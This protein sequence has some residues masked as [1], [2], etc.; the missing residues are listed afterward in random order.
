MYQ[1]HSDLAMVLSTLYG[2]GRARLVGNNYGNFV[3]FQVLFKFLPFFVLF[4]KTVVRTHTT[5]HNKDPGQVSPYS[6]NAFFRNKAANSG[7]SRAAQPNCSKNRF[8]EKTNQY[9]TCCFGIVHGMI[10]HICPLGVLNAE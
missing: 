3:V 4:R 9:H 10:C 7:H 5:V 1:S 6:D 8:I 2:E